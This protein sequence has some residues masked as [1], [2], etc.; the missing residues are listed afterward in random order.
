MKISEL[1]LKLKNILEDEGE[2]II[3]CDDGEEEIDMVVVD[4]PSDE[5]YVR[6]GWSGE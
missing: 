5:R 1:I 2:D 6:I 3:C 4:G